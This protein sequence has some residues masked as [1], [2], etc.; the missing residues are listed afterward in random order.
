ME[1]RLAVKM[2]KVIELVK[3][4]KDIIF[5]E[6]LINTRKEKGAADYAPWLYQGTGVY[7]SG[8]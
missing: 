6:T 4:T 1:S 3:S 7:I 2:Q 5:N 8:A